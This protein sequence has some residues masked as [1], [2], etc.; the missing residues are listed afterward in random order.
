[1]MLKSGDKRLAGAP[2]EE[3]V[4]KRR[5]FVA[6]MAAL[7]LLGVVNW[8]VWTLPLPEENGGN[9]V[10]GTMPARVALVLASVWIAGWGL[11]VWAWWGNM[12]REES[13]DVH[14][15]SAIG[16]RTYMFVYPAWLLLW[17]ARLV[18]EPHHL[19]LFLVSLV[20]AGAALR[21]TIDH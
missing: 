4:E 6:K 9:I 16:L 11:V 20:A 15:P 21:Y 19:A 12:D 2:A 13:S 17:N 3:R 7:M 14:W 8:V 10:V 1:M 18:P 5:E